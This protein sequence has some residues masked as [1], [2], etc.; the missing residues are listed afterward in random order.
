MIYAL[1]TG[2]AA[3]TGIGTAIQQRV[4]ARAPAGAT[5]HWRLLGYLLRQRLWLCG[6]AVAVVGNLL[7][8]AALGLG[9]VALVEP[10]TVSGL[11]F[12]MSV[13]AMWSRY[14]IGPREW[15]GALA[16]VVG[17]AA[18][19][20]AGRPRTG[21]LPN[22]PL[23]QWGLAAGTIG[24]IT[25]GLVHVARTLRRQQEAAMLGLGAG[26]LFG[27]Q[28][29]LTSTAAHRLFG[30]G[31]LAVLLSWTPYAIVAVAAVGMLLAQSAYKLAPLT[32]S[33]PAATAAEPIAGVAIGVGILGGALRIEPLAVA[34]E[35]VALAM[36]TTGVWVLGT[37]RLVEAHHEHRIHLPHH[38]RDDPTGPAAPGGPPGRGG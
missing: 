6:L 29:A 24:L 28:A 8:G 34:V 9:S 38:H 17:L 3:L 32:V 14:R 23:W 19:L 4:A 18:F 26:M 25:W 35:I 30:G 16:V 37:S 27:L 33:Y 36:M 21:P 13:A 2:A 7:T 11:L 1:A 12:A 10:L 31:P 5:L 15:L 22:P 20:V